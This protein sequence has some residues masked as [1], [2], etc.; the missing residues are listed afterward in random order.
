MAKEELS[1]GDVLLHEYERLKEEQSQR[2][3]T[4]DNLIY[5][6]L[7]SLA[8]VIAAYVQAN[9]PQM[10]LLIP[11]VCLVLGWTY[12]IND[13]KVSAIGRYVRTELAPRLE[14]LVGEPVLGWETAHRED[15]RRVSRKAGQLVADAMVFVVP[16]V[17]ALV[18]FWLLVTSPDTVLL[19]VAGIELILVLVLFHQVVTYAEIRWRRSGRSD[20]AAR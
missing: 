5:A 15:R 18:A 3:G 9:R 17:A 19:A 10:L 11:P 13:E 1:V 14:G 12:L 2:I 16:A 20:D 6:T 8:A 4:R 7:I